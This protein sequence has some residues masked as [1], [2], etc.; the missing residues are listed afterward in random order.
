MQE[1][2]LPP[3]MTSSLYPKNGVSFVSTTIVLSVQTKVEFMRI[4]TMGANGRLTMVRAMLHRFAFAFLVGA[5]FLIM[6]LGRNEGVLIEKTRTVILDVLSPAFDVL[7]RPAAAISN[8]MTYMRNLTN[9]RAENERL[10]AENQRLLQWH[11]VATK[12][13]SEN[14][15]L[16]Q[17]L[18]FIPEPDPAFLSA[19][20][21]GDV[22]SGF[23]QS[24]LLAAGARDGVRK[25]QAVLSGE[26]LVGYI[27]QVA[28]H[29]SRLLLLTDI[30]AHL[31]VV[32]DSTHTRAIL[33]GDNHD[34]PR[35]DY[36]SGNA[37]IQVGDLVVTSASG[38][39]FPPGLTIGAIAEISDGIYRVAPSV[40]REQLEYVTIVDYGMGGVLPFTDKPPPPAA[41]RVKGVDKGNDPN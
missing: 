29:V 6:M 2:V 16:H 26:F 31:P 3:H 33:S 19:R 14:A 10:K 22:A 34:M 1:N 13:A 24:L 40:R 21:I 35:L 11:T 39:A 8:G 18:N 32:V 27:G 37:N 17:Q 12:L 38:A 4:K 5:A 28:E 9:I 20:V 41:K 30:N 36:L 15:V 23:G 7:S 25:G